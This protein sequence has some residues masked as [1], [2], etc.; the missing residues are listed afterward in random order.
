[1]SHYQHFSIEERESIWEKQIKGES[2]RRIAAELG[3]SASTISRELKRNQCKQG[4]RPSDAQKQYHHRRKQ[5]RRHRLLA[6]G[7]LRATV[8][9]LLTQQ[10]WSPE[11][12][13][14]R[15]AM[16]HGKRLVSYST[17]Y[18]ALKDGYME[19]KGTRKNRHGRYPMQ[20]YLRRKGWRGVKKLRKT[21]A[22][23]HQTIEQRPKAADR[24]SQFGHFE[25]DL[26]YSSFHKL[27]VVTLV[28]RRSRYLLTG[29]CQSRK[30]EEVA[31]VMASMLDTLP[32]GK[33]RS[34]TLD[35]GLEFAHHANITK[36]IPNAVFYFPHPHAPWERGTNENTNGLLRQYIPKDT[37]KVPF[38]PSLLASFTDKLNRRPRKCLGWKSPL[39]LFFHKP[40]HF[41]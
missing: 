10:Q 22:F 33:L 9:R 17:I 15:M 32:K 38:S 29:I 41:T 24:R 5:C 13:S 31:R 12:I 40:L 37:Y 34:I 28:D 4:Y 1:M 16:E 23:V 6:P 20:K 36:I 25:G 18:R 2:V 30:P 39:E 19:P 27:Y 26:V 21:A 8:V 14:E 11:Q 3:R 7:P 35:R